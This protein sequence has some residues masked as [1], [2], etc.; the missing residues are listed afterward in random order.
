M[1][2]I[3]FCLINMV[4]SLT[5]LENGR[6]FAHAHLFYYSETHMVCASMI[7]TLFCMNFINFVQCLV[8]QLVNPPLNSFTMK[9]SWQKTCNCH[10]E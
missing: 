1:H 7:Q 6:S 10:I 3:D 5:C 4:G 8:L 9:A 2:P